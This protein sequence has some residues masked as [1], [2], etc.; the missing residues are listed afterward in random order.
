M[1]YTQSCR[2][3]ISTYLYLWG[4]PIKITPLLPQ[5]LQAVLSR[6][7]PRTQSLNRFACKRRMGLGMGLYKW[8]MSR[9]WLK[10]GC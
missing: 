8:Q 5:Q 6:R 9:W 2:G 7:L 3:Y 4:I 1:L 10:Y